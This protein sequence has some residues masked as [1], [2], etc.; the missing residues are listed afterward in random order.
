MANI[1]VG[2][3]GHPSH[4]Q[5]LVDACSVLCPV[6]ACFRVC[7]QPQ[8]AR[9]RSKKR[10]ASDGLRHGDLTSSTKRFFFFKWVSPQWGKPWRNSCWSSVSHNIY[11]FVVSPHASPGENDENGI[12]QTCSNPQDLRSIFPPGGIEPQRCLVQGRWVSWQFFTWMCCKPAMVTIPVAITRGS[13]WIIWN[14]D[15]ANK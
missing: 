10:S 5:H 12:V 1:V 4:S 14:R 7:H 2:Y 8:S 6:A 11:Q 9:D 15:V 3:P 13:F